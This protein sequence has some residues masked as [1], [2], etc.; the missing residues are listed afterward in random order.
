MKKNEYF[1][2]MSKKEKAAYIWDYYHWAILGTAV[3]IIILASVVHDVTKF[4][5][6]TAVEITMVGADSGA[7]ENSTYFDAYLTENGYDPKLTEVTVNDALSTSA[8][9]SV[10]QVLDAQVMTGDID[11]LISTQDVFETM[12]K[13]GVYE[14]LSTLLPADLLEK[15]KADLISTESEDQKKT[16]ISGIRISGDTGIGRQ[17]FFTGDAVAGIPVNAGH[18]ED[19]VKMLT[20]MLEHT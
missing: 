16:I 18:Q 15:Y 2:K 19:A 6:E 17:N 12:S 7:V 14:D 9:S 13:G 8:G 10:L 5:K 3:L 20:Y 1:Q 4:R 11:I